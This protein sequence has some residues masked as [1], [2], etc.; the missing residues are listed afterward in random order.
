VVLRG[1]LVLPPVVL[2][3]VVLLPA[4][5]LPVHFLPGGLPVGAFLWGH[6]RFPMLGNWCLLGQA[7]VSEWKTY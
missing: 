5:L 7:S 1:L 4:V 3:L 6:L 2:Q